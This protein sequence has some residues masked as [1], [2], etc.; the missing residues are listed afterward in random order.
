MFSFI[1]NCVGVRML[2]LKGEDILNSSG[3][4]QL[5]DDSDVE[6][7]GLLRGFDNLVSR[8]EEAVQ[9][10][11]SQLHAGGEVDAVAVSPVRGAAAGDVQHARDAP[12][13]IVLAMDGS[14]GSRAF[15]SQGIHVVVVVGS[16][17]LESPRK[18][19]ELAVAVNRVVENKLVLPG[20]KEVTDIDIFNL[21]ECR[22]SVV[23]VGAPVIGGAA[24][25]PVE[26]PVAVCI[27]TLA[28]QNAPVAGPCL[29]P[30]PVVVPRPVVAIGVCRG[31]DEPVQVLQEVGV[32]RVVLHQLLEHPGGGGW[33]DPLPSVDPTVDPHCWLASTF[34]PADLGNPHGPSLSTLANLLSGHK[35][36]LSLQVVQVCVHVLKRMVLGP[37]HRMARGH[38][39]H[40]PPLRCRWDLFLLDQF[41]DI[42]D[43]KAVLDVPVLQISQKLFLLF[44]WNHDVN[45][46][47]YSNLSPEV[48]VS[49]CQ[50]ERVEEVGLLSRL[51][52]CSKNLE[53]REVRNIFYHR[54]V[55]TQPKGEKRGK[56]K[57][58]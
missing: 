41:L 32:G 31:E 21:R 45:S 43:V 35:V 54:I 46:T 48:V 12:S 37:S 34:T 16:F 27:H 58:A 22:W 15:H 40:L 53:V 13:L 49:G 3:C 5:P 38:S 1:Y 17:I 9:A 7:P 52:R 26:S 55:E 44:L 25:V 8:K 30:H 24:L 36:K 2:Q 57:K 20:N 42:V 56:L 19:D 18:K 28:T 50:P 23:S 39:C 51:R 29:P 6:R 47:T 4:S 10:G 33:G 14:Q 11:V